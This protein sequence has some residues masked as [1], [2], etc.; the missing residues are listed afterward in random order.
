MIGPSI[1]F[2]GI[3]N[4][5]PE[6]DQGGGGVTEMGKEE[7]GGSVGLS[8]GQWH[9]ADVADAPPRGAANLNSN[10]NCLALVLLAVMPIF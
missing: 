8:L 4:G 1:S 7:A 10:L 2:E 5:Q 3:N 6:G 9:I